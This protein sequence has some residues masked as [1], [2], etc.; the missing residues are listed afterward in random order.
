MK[1][2]NPKQTKRYVWIAIGVVVL[3]IV[4]A[5]AILQGIAR[6]Q[7]KGMVTALQMILPESTQVSPDALPESDAPAVTINDMSVRGELLVPAV[8][9]DVALLEEYNKKNLR[10]SPCI[11]S[12]TVT[13]RDLVIAGGTY[14]S[15]FGKL[16]TLTKGDTV[17][18]CDMDGNLYLYDVVAVDFADRENALEISDAGYDLS[19]YC[20]TGNGTARYAARCTMCELIEK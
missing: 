19:L 11:L 5:N 2:T 12:G 9:V 10:K 7:A 6:S 4:L 18:F 17:M 16:N 1:K 20:V 13:G 8:Y 3:V 14:K 15:H